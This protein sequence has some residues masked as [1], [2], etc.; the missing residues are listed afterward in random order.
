[1][2]NGDQDIRAQ[3]FNISSKFSQLFAVGK[4]SAEQDDTTSQGI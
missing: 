2:I 1:M 3:L 4:V